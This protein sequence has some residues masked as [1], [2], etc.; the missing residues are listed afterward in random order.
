[1]KNGPYTLIVPPDDYP[2]KRYRG[3]YAYEHRV[4]FWQVHGRLPQR[5]HVVHHKDEKKRS[6]D[7][8]NLEEKTVQ[9]HNADHN[10]VESVPVKCGLCSID[11]YLKPSVYRYRLK[12]TESG[13][14]FCGREHQ[15]DWQQTSGHGPYTKRPRTHGTYTMYRDGCRCQGCTTANTQRCIISRRKRKLSFRDIA[16][17]E[18]S[19]TVNRE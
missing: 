8:N 18:T 17:G 12:R 3:R 13:L 2:G 7:P 16:Q 11:F 6:N 9:Q 5:G 10:I 15:V 4:V 1:M 14:L 19:T